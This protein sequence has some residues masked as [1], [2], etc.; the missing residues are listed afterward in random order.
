MSLFCL[1]LFYLKQKR[2]S[3]QLFLLKMPCLIWLPFTSQAPSCTTLVSMHYIGNKSSWRISQV[4]Y[5][6]L[7]TEDT[8]VNKAKIPEVWHLLQS[9]LSPNS[10]HTCTFFPPENMRNGKFTLPHGCHGTH[11]YFHF[12]CY[13]FRQDFP[14]DPTQASN[15]TF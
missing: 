6:F 12:N 9:S 1:S 10:S 11:S 14:S 5:T 8:T 3:L 2:S 15:S 4:P 13:L 7:G